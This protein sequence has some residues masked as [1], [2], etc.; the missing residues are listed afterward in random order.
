MA[1]PTSQP[2][3]WAILIGVKGVHGPN[4]ENTST[5]GAVA[6]VVAI[7]KYLMACSSPCRIFTLTTLSGFTDGSVTE[8]RVRLDPTYKN[9]ENFLRIVINE[10]R[11][12]DHVYIHYSGHGTTRKITDSRKE[13]KAL[14]LVVSQP[15][16]TDPKVF[17]G[18]TLRAA[19]NCMVKKGMFVTAVLDCCFSGN[20][21][22]QSPIRSSSRYLP[23]V[24]S[25]DDSFNMEN[26]FIG[27]SLR[28]AGLATEGEL[29]D[30]DGYSILTACGIDE[31]A[32]EVIVDG[33]NRGALSYFLLDSLNMLQRLRVQ[34]SHHTLHQHLRANFSARYQVQTPRLY[35]KTGLSFFNEATKKETSRSAYS[36]DKHE[37]ILDAGEIHGVHVDDEYALKEWYRATSTANRISQTAVVTSVNDVNSI[38][39]MI[40]DTYE[41]ADNDIWDAAMLTTLS[42]HRTRIT[43]DKRVPNTTVILNSSKGIPFLD[44]ALQGDGVPSSDILQTSSIFYVNLAEDGT[45]EITDSTANKL[46]NFPSINAS[47]RNA[48]Q[49]L[50]KRLSHIATYRFY[51]RIENLNP[52]QGFCQSFTLEIL[53]PS[54]DADGIYRIDQKDGFR[55]KFKNLSSHSRYLA[56][57][58][59]DSFWEVS[60]LFAAKGDSYCLEIHPVCS[61][62]SGEL[63]IPM[64]LTVVPELMAQGLDHADDIL[65]VFVTSEQTFFHDPVLPPIGSDDFRSHGDSVELVKQRMWQDP[66]H[67]GELQ[68]PLVVVAAVITD[69]DSV[70]I[71]E[72]VFPIF[73]AH[74]EEGLA[75]RRNAWLESYWGSFREG[76]FVAEALYLQPLDDLSSNVYSAARVE[77]FPDGYPRFSALQSSHK[78]F[79]IFRRFEHLRVRL[80]LAKQD[81]L[82]ILEKRLNKIDREEPAPVFLSSMRMNGSSERAAIISEIEDALESYGTG[83]KITLWPCVDRYSDDLLERTEKVVSYDEPL[84]VHIT[85]LQNWLRGNSCIAQDEMSFLQM[86]DDLLVLAPLEDGVLYWLETVVTLVIGFFSKIPYGSYC[87]SQRSK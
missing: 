4:R 37:L 77:S 22:R 74:D 60:S 82:S 11:D 20:V 44:L 34:I 40:D 48:A 54:P 61:E 18:T 81:K 17:P 45:Y 2:S 76:G 41:F 73:I 28:G 19:I 64:K 59:F 53:G 23:Y 78:Y 72:P 21:L 35:G 3:R 57:L 86:K 31:E 5:L 38:L 79:H 62:N 85:S 51:Q 58:A 14:G 39:N 69:W 27:E 13:K 7:E 6:D 47:D 75:C 30:P 32:G 46:A 29:L 65:K 83:F 68:V 24:S 50:V 8:S 63:E 36:N 25:M 71:T 15:T 10:G 43:I 80:L 16:D 70:P 67:R 49:I 55:F 1:Q 9:L 26:P 87:V 33:N 42:P 12:G 52:D 84:D 56:I 66:E